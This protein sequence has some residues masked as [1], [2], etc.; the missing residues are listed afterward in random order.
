MAVITP[1]SFDPLKTRCNVRLQ[2]GVPIVDADWNELD[3]IRKFEMRA[4]VKWFV[5][6]GIPDANDGFR[7]DAVGAADDF[8]IRAGGSTPASGASNA[9]IALRNVGRCGAECL[10]VIM[11][12]DVNFH[13]QPV[14]IGAPAIAPIPVV[15]GPVTV[16]LDVWERLVTFQE[17]PSLVLPGLGTESCARVKRS[18]AVR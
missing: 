5:G 1:S 17:D 16:Y 6:D 2:Q 3:D 9:E 15:T 13:A 4:F 14:P 10:D 18:F 12:C 8:V 11:P 7:I